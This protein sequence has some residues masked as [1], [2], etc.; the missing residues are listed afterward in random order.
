MNLLSSDTLFDGKIIIS[1]HV[2]GYRFSID[3]LLLASFA[4]P[5]ANDHIL[6]LGSGCGILSILLAY[7]N[8]EIKITGVEIQSQLY[9][10]SKKNIIKNNMDSRIFIMKKN[11]RILK[12]N[13]FN[14]PI[15]MIISNPPYIKVG[16]GRI[17]PNDEQAIAKHEIKIKLSDLVKV[18]SSLLE[19]S[20]C[21]VLIYPALRIT[22]LL[23]E[24]RLNGIEPKTLRMIHSR[25]KYDAKLVLIKGVKGGNPGIKVEPPL[26]IYKKDKSYSDEVKK[27]YLA[28]NLI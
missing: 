11:I 28:K 15:N 23:Y 4:K 20:G 27:I 13:H 10:L 16:S 2:K 12:K 17:N 22:D 7:R 6:D 1:Q 19:K 26:V 25:K 21:F 8:P 18:S 3:P 24:M 14:Y 5:F 9:D